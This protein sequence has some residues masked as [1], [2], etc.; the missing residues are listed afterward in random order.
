MQ[1][2]PEAAQSVISSLERQRN[3]ALNQ[4]AVAE[5]QV[6]ALDAALTAAQK[7]LAELR[8]A[9]AALEKAE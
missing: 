1:F 6:S 4:L 5:A 7:E 9:D 2:T 8:S 3:T